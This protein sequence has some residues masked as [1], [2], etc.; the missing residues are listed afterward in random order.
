MNGNLGRDQC[1][2]HE[3]LR[4][5]RVPYR[6]NVELMYE[7]LA[8][9]AWFHVLVRTRDDFGVKGDAASKGILRGIVSFG[10]NERVLRGRRFKR[11]HLSVGRCSYPFAYFSIIVL[12]HVSIALRLIWKMLLSR[13]LK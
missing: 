13:Y 2:A 6:W 1:F 3:I 8:R 4:E 10:G 7:E 5:G 11:E 12:V 9:K